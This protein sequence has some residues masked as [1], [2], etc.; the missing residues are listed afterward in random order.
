MNLVRRGL[1][2]MVLLGS[3]IPVASWAQSDDRS[4]EVGWQAA[5][6][7]P[8]N[9]DPQWV[10]P[11]TTIAVAKMLPIELFA[12][13][14]NILSDRSTILLPEGTELIGLTSNILAACSIGNS[15]DKNPL[16]I[17]S[18][19][20]LVD[21]NKDGKFD[22][23]FKRP[24]IFS[25]HGKIP[26]DL[27]PIASGKY[28]RRDIRSMSRPPRL[29]VQYGWF[30]SLANELVFEICFRENERADINCRFDEKHPMARAGIPTTFELL[31]AR[32]RVEAKNDDRV[33]VR[34]ET[35]FRS[36]P[37]FIR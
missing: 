18:D 20:C 25:G 7:Q 30:A 4:Y 1:I 11:H 2:V 22:G 28:I 29:F 13:G 26:K 36:P 14:E 23:Y 31:G 24:W 21:T 17:N 16:F 12:T 33:Q 3:S 32:F 8:F 6:D 27:K 19:I 37:I 15:K 35:P 9:T 5:P 34:M 10:R